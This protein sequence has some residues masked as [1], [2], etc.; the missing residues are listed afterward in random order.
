MIAEQCDMRFWK[1][2]WKQSFY[3]SLN[4]VVQFFFAEYIKS[5]GPKFGPIPNGI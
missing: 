4:V 3:T 1:S 5:E 2:I